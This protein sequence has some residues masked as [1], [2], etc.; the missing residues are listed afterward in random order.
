MQLVLP[1]HAN[2]SGI[3]EGLL[4]DRDGWNRVTDGV[5]S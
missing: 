2:I 5:N 1:I 4:V 3:A